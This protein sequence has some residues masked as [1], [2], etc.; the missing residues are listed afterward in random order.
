[1]T[2]LDYVKVWDLRAAGFGCIVTLL[3]VG[4]A[5]EEVCI[6]LSLERAESLA[7]ELATRHQCKWST[8]AGWY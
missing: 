2:R 1:M 7:R 8:S 3:R 6:D 5:P 4:H